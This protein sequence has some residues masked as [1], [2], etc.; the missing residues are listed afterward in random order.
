[1]EALLSTPSY[2]LVAGTI[3]LIGLILGIFLGDLMDT[4]G[5]PFFDSIDGWISSHAVFTALAVFGGIGIFVHQGL[6]DILALLIALAGCVAAFIAIAQLMR[7]LHKQ[8]GDSP[9]SRESYYASLATVT[10]P[11][12]AGGKLGEVETTN[13]NG[14]RVRLS[15]YTSAEN[16]LSVRTRVIIKRVETGRVFVIP[17]DNPSEEN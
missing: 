16:S 17:L 4:Y 3:G 2:Y 14:V 11:I 15:A 12:G 8:Q 6:P 1:M 9:V 7:W 10:A 13:A 5:A